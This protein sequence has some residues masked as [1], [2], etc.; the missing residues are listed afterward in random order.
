MDPLG[1]D[2]RISCRCPA[3]DL[4]GNVPSALAREHGEEFPRIRDLAATPHPGR[5]RHRGHFAP[6]R[7]VEGLR[8]ADR[9]VEVPTH[10]PVAPLR[11]ALRRAIEGDAGKHPGIK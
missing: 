5:E 7:I 8:E 3:L 11:L 9:L 1:A 2:N 4:A 6:L 10:L